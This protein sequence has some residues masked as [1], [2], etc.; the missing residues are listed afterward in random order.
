MLGTSLERWFFFFLILAV[1]GFH[2]S[3]LAS[4]VVHG[5]SCSTVCGVLVSPPGTESASPAL[6]GGFST[7]GPPGTSL[8][9]WYFLLC[10]S[11]APH[12]C[13]YLSPCLHLLVPSVW[14]ILTIPTSSIS[15]QKSSL[16]LFRALIPITS[17]PPSQS[18]RSCFPITALH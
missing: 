15:Q 11:K 9:G 14:T 16:S 3:A 7:S 5:L 13:T 12:T 2:C 6:E 17:F 18:P 10:P 4:L 8:E 1:P